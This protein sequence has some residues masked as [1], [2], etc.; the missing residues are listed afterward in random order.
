MENIK[1]QLEKKTEECAVIKERIRIMNE[2]TKA[3]I[4]FGTWEMVKDIINPE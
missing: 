3:E 1:E 4:P 2:F